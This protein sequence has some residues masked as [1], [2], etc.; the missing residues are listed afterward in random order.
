MHAAVLR[1]RAAALPFLAVAWVAGASG[2]TVPPWLAVTTVVVAVAITAPAL[3][4]RS[5][6]APAWWLAG[7]LAWAA[8]DAALR[9]VATF[10]AARSIAM[11]VTA[12]LLGAAAA[13]PRGAAW[14]RMAVA[15]AGLLSAA[16]LLAERLVHSGRPEGPFLNPNLGA[17]LALLAISLA[18]FL[19]IPTVLRVAAG[20]V[21]MTG[22]VASGSRGALLGACAVAIVWAVTGTS[23]AFRRLALAV[24]GA[25]AI[26]LALRLSLDRD[27]LR[28]ERLRIWGVAG[29]TAVAE[30]PLGC[31]PGGYA[32]AALPHN[33]PLAG[34]FARYARLPDLAESDFLQVLATLGAPGIVL[35][36][37]L[38]VSIGR[39]LPRND[40]RG[41]GVVVA[42]ATTSL[43]S[44]QLVV[45][46]VAW[47]AALA[48]A[49]VLPR[50]PRAL[51]QRSWPLLACAGGAVVVAT[52]A[53]LVLP[54]WGVGEAPDRLV[55]R[56]AA[57]LRS[58]S[59]TDTSLADAEV[60]LLRACTE[61][62]R[63][64]RAWRELGTVRIARA[65]LR[66][67]RDLAAAAARAFAQARTLNKVDAFAT[68]GEG[69]A[70]RLLGDARGA[71]AAIGA[72]L[73]VEPNFVSAWFELAALQV[74][75]GELGAAREAL[76]RLAA[77]QAKAQ[78]ASF[79]SEYERALAW[80]DPRLIGQLRRAVGDLP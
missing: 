3:R 17:T 47:A 16:W 2:V 43:F 73:T 75:R 65:R 37:G 63:Y 55:D 6:P 76:D 7:L 23:A 57:M 13:T 15:A 78:A 45:P 40:V 50:G 59:A 8:A 48:L 30:L 1:H 31:G 20:G 28:F 77:A 19:P 33:F 56:A 67:E 24:V 26:G 32:D 11:G 34:G 51:H 9:P 62:P 27:P 38:I 68:L 72:A 42:I 58:P 4:R 22:L 25:G 54:D 12:L 41:W 79:V 66:G 18:P 53:V 46:V 71:E 35:V 74:E 69:Q 44:T 10:D 64:G 49:A 14:G 70:L 52:A 29:R 80:A 36:V 21:A 39:R 5:L 61:R 60:L